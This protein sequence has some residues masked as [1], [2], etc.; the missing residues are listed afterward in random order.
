[1]RRYNITKPAGLLLAFLLCALTALILFNPGVRAFTYGDVNDDGVVDVRDVVLVMRHILDLETLDETGQEL[2]DVNTDGVVDVRD[3]ALIM[4]K[5]L[6]LIDHFPDTGQEGA[7]L[8]EE[9]L[10]E[11]GISPG[12]K[13]VVV[14]LNVS[15]PEDYTVKVGETEL[16]YR[17][18]I[19]GFRGE[20]HV[21]EAKLS[22]VSVTRAE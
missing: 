18:S 19:D 2:A 17:D 22:K 20:T 7:A 21:E 5:A 1:M 3:A 16:E 4:Q 14:I 15:G 12:K 13:M 11:E 10:V 9:F 6:G 8:I